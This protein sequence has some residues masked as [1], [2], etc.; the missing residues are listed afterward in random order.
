MAG[1]L[2]WQYTFKT[3]MHLQPVPYRPVFLRFHSLL[4]MVLLVWLT[5]CTPVVYSVQQD[6][7]AVAGMAI[8]DDADNPLAGTN[9]EKAGS[10]TAFSEY[11]HEVHVG[12]PVITSLLTSFKAHAAE[13][14]TLFHP[15][16]FSPPPEP[17]SR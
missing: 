16:L 2:Y 4:M 5:V 3:F 1:L 17:L 6:S 9:E 7:L 12:L 10:G 8:D 11:L 15:E 14:L 13:I